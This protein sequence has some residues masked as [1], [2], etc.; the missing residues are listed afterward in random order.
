MARHGITKAQ[1][2]AAADDLANE[3]VRPTVKL[4]RER[5]GTGSFSTITPLLNDW[6]SERGDDRVRSIPEMPEGVLSSCRSLWAVAWTASQD[7]LQAERDGLAAARRTLE[8]DRSDLGAEIM[9]LERKLETALSERDAALGKL[10][11]EEKE[12]RVRDQEVMTL[13]LENARLGE[14]VVQVEQRADELRDQVQRLEGELARLAHSG[15]ERAGS[16]KA[17]VPPRRKTSPPPSA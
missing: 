6:N 12:K 17:R 3:G 7:A 4:V 10:E 16:E 9:E 11:H 13:Q 15:A 2:F 5:I 1:V 8:Q 14:R